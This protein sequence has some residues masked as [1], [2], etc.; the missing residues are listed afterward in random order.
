VFPVDARVADT[1]A[2]AV[3]AFEQAGAHVEEV[4]VGINRPQ[5]WQD[6]YGICAKRPV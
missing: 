5:N 2:E 6:A 1:V 3:R 4:K